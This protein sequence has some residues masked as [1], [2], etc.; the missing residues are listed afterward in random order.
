MSE[1]LSIVTDTLTA[2]DDAV[3]LSMLGMSG[4][5]FQVKSTYSGT[6][7][8]EG[9]VDDGLWATM[10]VLALGATASATTTTSTGIFLASCA[11]LSQ[12]RARMSSFSS[13]YATVTIRAVPNAPSLPVLS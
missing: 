1:S 8:F 4:C 5:A 7:T 13:G 2:A 3:T 12:V 9:T 11:G 6:I 10:L